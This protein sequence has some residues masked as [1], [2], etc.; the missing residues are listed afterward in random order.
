[1]V[2][3]TKVS[4]LRLLIAPMILSC[5]LPSKD[6]SKTPELGWT[7][8]WEFE[9]IVGYSPRCSSSPSGLVRSM[10]CT[11]VHKAS[12]LPLQHHTTVAASAC[13]QGLYNIN[14]RNYTAEK[15]CL[16]LMFAF[17][18]VSYGTEAKVTNVNRRNRWDVLFF[19]RHVWL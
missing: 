18:L 11:Q 17:S 16:Q 19:L 3:N 10:P 14:Y 8:S 4:N 6:V 2:S 7:N 12:V 15:L 1:M 13:L 9:G 5:E